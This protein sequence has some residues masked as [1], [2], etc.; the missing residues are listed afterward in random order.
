MYKHVRM[1]DKCWDNTCELVLDNE[2][3]WGIGLVIL[4]GIVDFFS[5]RIPNNFSFVLYLDSS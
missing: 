2:T 1:N 4:P 3:I 5:S